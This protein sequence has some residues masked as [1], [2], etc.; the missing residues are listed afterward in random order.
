MEPQSYRDEQRE[1]MFLRFYDFDP[2]GLITFHI[3]TLSRAET[4][5][6]TQQI[7]T[8]RLWPLRQAELAEALA[9]AGLTG[10]PGTGTWSGP[11]F[12]L[13]TAGTW[14]SVQE[15]ISPAGSI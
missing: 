6:W 1:W 4:G 14:F 9:Q 15:G 10:S 2:D 8:T 13:N 5:P 12:S 11:P 3:V 7:A